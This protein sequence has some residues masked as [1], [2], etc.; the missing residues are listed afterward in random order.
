MAKAT[1]AVQPARIPEETITR[2]IYLIR[3]QKVM[4]D[5]DLSRLYQVATRV[6]L[7]A[8]KR[9]PNRFPED[10]MFRL[11]R[12][13]H[14]SLR[15]QSVISNTGRGGRRYLP[16]A[17]T[18]HGV[19]MVCS[20]LGSR[21]A[22]QMN[23]LIVRAFV[24]LR[25]LHSSHQD[26]ASRVERLESSSEHHTSVINILAEEIEELKQPPPLPPKRRIGFRAA[27]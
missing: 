23:I 17:F 14:E 22:I 5:S 27:G 11:S 21:R 10:F 3:G 2:S 15:S 7:Q 13:E 9:N 24:R 25:E 20:V 8:V 1:S 16:Y 19:V 4:I 6:L 18:E 26:L 12:K